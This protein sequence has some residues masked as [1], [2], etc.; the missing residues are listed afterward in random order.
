MCI[1]NIYKYTNIYIYVWLYWHIVIK[2]LGF[3]M[4]SFIVFTF[5]IFEC[6]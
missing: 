4:K 6:R 3:G 2:I 1:I 5:L